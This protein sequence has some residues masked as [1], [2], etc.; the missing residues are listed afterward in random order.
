MTHDRV[1]AFYSGDL[2]DSGR[3]LEEI[4]AWSDEELELVHDYIQWIFPTVQTSAVNPSAPLVT[5]ET[6]RAFRTEGALRARLKRSLD[7]MLTF[8]G[9]RREAAS[10]GDVHIEI[11]A[12]RFP[13]RS[14][15]WLCRGDHNHLRLTRIMQSLSALGLPDEARAL[16]RCLLGDIYAGP[17]RASIT[18]GTYEFWLTAVPPG[19]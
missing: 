16:Q 5:H 7:R 17:G 11:D 2:D 6:V 13:E 12:A 10:N 4:W 18:D 15:N 14:L 9:L 3:T 1:V 8:Y 19:R